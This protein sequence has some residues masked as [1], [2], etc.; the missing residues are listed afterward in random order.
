MRLRFVVLAV[1]LCAPSAAS[2]ADPT[3]TTVKLPGADGAQEPRVAV[4]RDD[5]RYA[6]ALGPS[7]DTDVAGAPAIVWRSR[8]GGQTWQATESAP[9]QRQAS[10]DV[11][12]ITL[13]SGRL[14]ASE[15]DYGGIDFPTAYSD[16]GGKTW[17]SSRG[18]VELVDQ[19]RQWFASGPLPK[20]AKP[21]DQP[22][23]YLL[24]HNL[25]S[26]VAQHNMFVST[27]ADGG[28]TFGPPVPIATPGSDAYLD[29]QCSDSGGPSNITVNPKT[30]RIYAIFTTR[31]TPTDNGDAGGCA[32]PI[33]GQPIE[34]NIVNG[35]RVWVATSKDGSLGSWT[36][37][38]AVDASKTGQVV[39]MQLAYGALDN[40]GNVYVAYPE[41]PH[42]YPN[43][44]GAAVK[45][46]WQT[47]DADGLLA[48]KKWSAPTTLVPGDGTDG[49]VG[50]ANLVH[51]VAGDP[52]RIA[53]AYYY[54]APAKAKATPYYAHILQSFDAQSPTPH[55]VDAKVSEIPA[56][57]WSTSEM[58]GLCEA[59]KQF[60]PVQGVYAGGACSRSTD[61]W[62]IALDA[63]CRVMSTWTSKLTDAT[64]NGSTKGL[65]NAQ[66]GTYVTTQTGGP[67]LCASASSTPG[68]SQGVPFQ[69]PPGTQPGVSGAGGKSCRDRVAP[70]SRVV[71]K[72]NLSRRSLKLRGSAI[73]HGCGVK[74]KKARARVR[75]VAVA[76]AFV[77]GNDRCR[78]VRGDGTFG[79]ISNCKHP[80]F[81]VA[82]GRSSW[83]LSLKGTFPK[84][85]YYIWSRA[86]DVVGNSQRKP[87][88]RHLV[89]VRVR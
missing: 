16:D 67:T 9:A 46:T 68:G 29:L 52:G 63:Q 30:G 13:P 7:R 34:F 35:T 55:V 37:S 89:H 41:S 8:D 44:E 84:G 32:G 82:S 21:G 40:V 47:P 64:T 20:N 69:P 6:V 71:G 45:L 70:G 65:P 58:M 19:D 27:S 4:G 74:G 23:V 5:V 3:Y 56:Y 76:V 73:D 26:G 31:A 24:Y 62:G 83:K 78:F 14:L 86:T 81:V 17:T 59:S 53:V 42:A 79:A 10:I 36:N 22:P 38:L 72:V 61:V 57:N 75:S 77:P 66:N 51:L 43:L 85:H 39:S 88:T 49:I 48:D 25:G 60:G 54:G 12:V 1:L 50:G 87:S 18:S 11:D 80:T 28:A 33:F 15:L 2:A